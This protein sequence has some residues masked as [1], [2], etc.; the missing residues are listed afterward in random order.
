MRWLYPVCFTT[1]LLSFMVIGCAPADKSAELQEL[2]QV[3]QD[4]AAQLL[5]EVPNAARY[6]Q[7]ARQY[8][9][10]SEEA[11]QD[12]REER[13]Q[14]YAILGLIRYRSAV[15]VARQFEAAEKLQVANSRIEEINPEV[16]ATSQS[17]NELAREIRELDDEI[18]QAVRAREEERR[19][20]E[21]ASR[22]TGF[23]PRQ[24]DSGDISTE[25]LREINEEIS[26]AQELRDAGLEVK[27]DEYD[28]T[29]GTFQRAQTQLDTAR[30]L[31]E[32]QPGA[33]DT[34]KRQV[35]FA[36]Q[37]FEE[38]RD[39]A[40]PIH[41]EMVEKMKPENRI[42][43]LRRE[44]QNNFGRPFTEEEYQGVRIVM[45]RLFV[46]GEADFQ[47]NTETMLNV[48]KGLASE[49]EEF[50]IQIHGFTRR[51]GGATQNLT[52]SQLRAHN[53]RD[54]LVE[55]GVDQSRIQ[56]EGFGQDRIRFDDSA[57]NN[58]RVEVIFRHT[59][60]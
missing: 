47:R 20:E 13:S 32:T 4:P 41:E 34:I 40:T 60:P 36:A 17:R 58:D 54:L 55:A 9:R 48:L 19:R 14:Q 7:E 49:Y 18:R 51:G 6:H 8:R 24:R 45:A 25:V 16:R 30:E 1:I 33:A 50:S 43:T 37:L 15:A 53:V 57:D 46:Q 26:R 42:A 31:L 35:G 28:R 38:A 10:A 22:E 11:R 21:S 39:T 56:T 27:A 3:L 2:E 12:R 44:A 5:R 23:D 52:T 29:R 59:N